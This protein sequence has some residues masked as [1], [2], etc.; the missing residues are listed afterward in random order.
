MGFCST[1]AQLAVALQYVGKGRNPIIFQIRMGEVD[2]GASLTEV[3]QFPGEAE[4]LFPPLSNF[5]L[6]GEP[7]MQLHDGR[8][9]TVLQ[10][11]ISVNVK[12]RTIDE[13]I[14]GRKQIQMQMLQNFL[15][16]SKRQ[17]DEVAEQRHAVASD[18]ALRLNQQ[19]QTADSEDLRTELLKLS[20]PTTGERLVTLDGN[21]V[22]I[23]AR[24]PAIRVVYVPNP[25]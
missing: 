24:R 6:E 15:D 17:E 4:I 12:S 16:E 13:L 9:I 23:P 5:E 22:R 10:L 25:D 18:L 19:L 3:S 7:R 21:A 2:H 8:P 11:G 1:T 14:E 20:H